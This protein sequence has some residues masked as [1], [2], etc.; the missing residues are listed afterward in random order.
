M[1]LFD[2]R[3]AIAPAW[4]FCLASL[5]SSAGWAELPADNIISRI[6]QLARAQLAR[7]AAA[8]GLV[9]PRFEVV[10]A[11]GGRQLAPCA[12]AVSVEPLDLRQPNRMRFVAACAGAGGWKY[13]FVARAAITARVAVTGVEVPAG[14]ALTVAEVALERRDVSAVADSVADPA[15]LLGL[16]SRRN[17]RAGEMLRL[18]QLVAPALVKRGEAVQIVARRGNVEVTMAGEALEAGAQDAVLRVRNANSGA[19]IRARVV[20]AGTV[21]PVDLPARTQLPD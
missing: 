3:R 17:L 18:G 14:R 4:L 8:A 10:V 19:V 2:A 6:E 20:A 7:Q 21:E 13:D 16:A 1:S 12:Q 9:E 11:H 5:Y 15:A